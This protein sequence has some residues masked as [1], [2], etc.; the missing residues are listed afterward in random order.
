MHYCLN[1]YILIPNWSKGLDM[2]LDVA[3]VNSLRSDYVEREAAEPGYALL[4]AFTRKFN[5]IGEACRTEGIDFVP[6]PVEVLGGWSKSA[7]L[8]L[9]LLS[10]AGRTG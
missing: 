3:V 10:R 8:Q 7:S 1:I 2:A 5:Q 4:Q 9:T 6:L